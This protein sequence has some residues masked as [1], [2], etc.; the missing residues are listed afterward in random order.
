MSS[1]GPFLHPFSRPAAGPEAFIKMV[2]AEGSTVWDD[3]GNAYVDALAS[4]WY[5]NVGHGNPAIKAA[6]AAQLDRLD[7]FQTFDRFTNEP[8][9]QVAARLA[10]IAPMPNVRV[11]LTTG[12][13]ESVETA[14]KLARLAHFAAG[15]PER[16]VVISR[17]PSYH[18]VNFGGTSVTGLPLNQAGFGPLLP[19]VVQVPAHDLAAIDEVI[20]EQGGDRIAAIIAEPVIG[21]GGVYPPAESELA[22]L[23]ERC[24]R[25]G[26]FL[27]LDEVICGFGRLGH[28]WGGQRYGVVPDLVTFAKGV[29]SGYL[30]L[31]GVLLGR[32][33]RDPL[34]ADG[35]LILRHGYTYS[36]H[37]VSC[38]AA[39]ANLQV[40][41]EERLWERADPV[42][43]RLSGGLRELM[44][45]ERITD[46]RGD[47]AMWGIQLGPRL[48]A[49]DVREALL[50]NGVIARP[51]GDSIVAFCPPLVISDAEIDKIVDAVDRSTR[52]LVPSPTPGP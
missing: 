22:G 27:I 35:T 10:E 3:L 49:L 16:T 47:G 37:P 11:F 1:P 39:V 48:V 34:E 36:G 31:G 12:G 29:T 46:V 4:L 24:D 52:S 45:G 25:V 42:G 50:E 5:C 9:E 2:R 17:K 23:R 13:S 40:M 43:A 33:V 32:A 19:D 20:A 28:W 51:I 6:I 41:T 26:A 14:L 30:P 21:A 15:Q 44:D 38:A 7:C 18:G 8:A